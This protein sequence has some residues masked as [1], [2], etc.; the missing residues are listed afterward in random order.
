MSYFSLKSLPMKNIFLLLLL[1]LT[2]LAVGSRAQIIT[3]IA[4]TGVA[5][6]TGD[7]GP[8]INAKIRGPIGIC[9]DKKGIIYF[10]DDSY[11]IKKISSTG[12]LSTFAG[13]GFPGYSGDG[14]SATDAQ[15]YGCV[16]IVADKTGNI[17]FSDFNEHVIRKIDTAGIITTIAG[18]G[19]LGFGGD[20]GPATDATLHAPGFLTIDRKGNIYFSDITNNRIRKINTAGIITTFA[21]TGATGYN[22]DG[23]PATDASI[24]QP[25]GIAVDSGN[26]IYIADQYNG[27]IRK[28]DTAGMISTIAGNG[29]AGYSGDG[30][31]ATNALVWGLEGMIV[32]SGNNIY[33]ADVGNYRV[34][35]ISANGIINAIAG[36]GIMGYAG[37]GGNPLAGSFETPTDIAI[38]NNGNLYITDRADN[39]IRA[40][41]YNVGL[42]QPNMGMSIHSF[43]NPNNGAFALQITTTVTETFEV[44][45]TDLTGREVLRTSAVSNS[46]TDNVLQVPDGV[47]YLQATNEHGILKEKIVV[48]N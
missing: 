27:R 11:K 43:P 36:N 12:I 17:Y 42:F 30:G 37:D 32:D 14:G 10:S 47:Y 39:R 1:F 9:C 24:F 8:A 5:G 21:G 18:I 3:T 20:G 35:K 31:P 26:N 19:S 6:N 29:T 38:A 45:V 13:T 44:S 40:I 23:I 28:V 33:F 48:M 2:G 25:S 46:P 4:G 16:G 34:R 41:S 7:G 22:G 15:I